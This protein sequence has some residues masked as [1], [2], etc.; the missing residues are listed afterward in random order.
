[1]TLEF[2]V[3]ITEI[4][5]IY[6]VTIYAD[7][8]TDSD[9]VSC[10]RSVLRGS[11]GRNIETVCQLFG[12][13][14]QDAMVTVGLAGDVTQ[15]EYETL[16]ESS[17]ELAGKLMIEWG[18]NPATFDDIEENK[19]VELFRDSIPDNC[20]IEEKKKPKLLN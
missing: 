13:C 19:L 9:V 3:H 2:S 8:G 10:Y 14:H 12:Q 17:V 16:M 6:G 18:F 20:E 7:D 5:G 15:S 4:S 1:M 11:I